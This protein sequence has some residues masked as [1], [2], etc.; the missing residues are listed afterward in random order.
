MN[1]ENTFFTSDTHYFHKNIMREDFSNRPFNDVD[2]MNEELIKSWNRVVGE[3]D[4]VYH[5]GDVSLGSASK[6]TEIIRRLNGHKHLILGNHE[7]SVMRKEA[8]R[9]LFESIQAGLNIRV[10]GID[11]YLHHYACRVWNKSHRGSYHLYG[12]S[13]DSL[14]YEEWGRSMDVSVDTAARILG[15]YRPFSFEEIN[16]I[17]SKREFKGV[18]HHE[19]R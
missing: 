10:D 14:E 6:T 18:D 13:H 19:E 12:H 11:L 4:T 17:L 1:K 15:E 7:K 16:R 3:D 9:N 2:H 8:T 5:L